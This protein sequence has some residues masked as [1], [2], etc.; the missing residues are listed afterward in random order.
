M[1]IILSLPSYIFPSK[2]S[3]WENIE[4]FLKRLGRK[5]M[6]WEKNGL[7]RK[8]VRAGTSPAT[9]TKWWERIQ[10]E[11]KSNLFIISFGQ[12]FQK[13][14]VKLGWLTISKLKNLSRSIIWFVTVRK[15]S[16]YKKQKYTIGANQ[17]S[18]DF[19]CKWCL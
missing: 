10:S 12:M 15:K 9:R 13:R 19:I 5:K 2:C 3:K 4:N 8:G 17:F 6:I 14:L 11:C 7:E 18:R 1:S 16:P